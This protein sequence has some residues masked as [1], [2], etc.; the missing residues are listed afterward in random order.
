MMVCPITNRA[1]I[2]PAIVHSEPNTS[3]KM[4][5]EKKYN[6]ITRGRLISNK[7]SA[8]FLKSGYMVDFFEFFLLNF[9]DRLEIALLK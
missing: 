8:I 2:S 3:S 5:I 9:E 7:T 6:S 4:G 1:V